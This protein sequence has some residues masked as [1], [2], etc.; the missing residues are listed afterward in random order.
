LTIDYQSKTTVGHHC[1]QVVAEAD[2]AFDVA[3]VAVV[4]AALLLAVESR[5]TD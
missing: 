2:A 3:A 4:V 5:Q 1:T